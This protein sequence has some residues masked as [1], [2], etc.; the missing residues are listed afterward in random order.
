M[1]TDFHSFYLLFIRVPFLQVFVQK[2][3]EFLL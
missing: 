3:P 1:N 2:L